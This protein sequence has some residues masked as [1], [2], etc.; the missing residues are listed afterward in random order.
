MNS[1]LAPPLIY[2]DGKRSGVRPWVIDRHLELHVSEVA[3]RE[4][5][6][7]AQ[8]LRVGVTSEIE[9]GLVV[10]AV[11]G[12]LYQRQERRCR[13]RLLRTHGHSRKRFRKVGGVDG[14]RAKRGER[15]ASRAT[16]ENVQ[17]G[18]DRALARD[19][20]GWTGLEPAASG[21]TGRRSNQLNYHP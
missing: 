9:P 4:S 13:S 8:F 7:Q 18:T 20:A 10:E 6:C 12:L 16:P 17:P 19:V 3:T 21:V 11:E 15:D 14:T 1:V 2:G 5:L